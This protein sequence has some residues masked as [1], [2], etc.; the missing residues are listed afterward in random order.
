MSAKIKASIREKY[1]DF[2]K[3]KILDDLVDKVIENEKLK[4]E[5]EKLEKE[6]KKYKNAHTPSSKLRFEKPQAKGL[7]VG[8][9]EGK[10]SNHVGKTRPQDTPTH[11]IWVKAEKNPITGNTNIVETGEV[12]EAVITDFEIKKIV[13]LYKLKEYRDLDTGEI[14]LARHPDIP[15]KGIFGKNMQAFASTLHADN[16][17]TFDGIASIFTNVFGISITAPT[18]M[19]LCNRAAEK[20]KPEYV[21]LNEELK[22]QML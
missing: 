2:D 17:V 6:L 16:R 8:R 18:A 10:K 14:F 15:D 22:N 1:E 20:T 11:T 19:E 7:P 4:K 12:V 9:R 13:T 21:K 3:D 5:K